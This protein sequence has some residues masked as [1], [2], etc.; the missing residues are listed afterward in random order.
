MPPAAVKNGY[1]TAFL[2]ITP[3]QTEQ[4]KHQVCGCIDALS[5]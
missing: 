2:P 1:A 3:A 4:E 5:I